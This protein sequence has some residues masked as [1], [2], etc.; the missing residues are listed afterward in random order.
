MKKNGATIV[1]IARVAG[2]SVSTVSRVTHNFPKIAESTRRRV[3]Q[4]IEELSYKPESRNFSRSARY[5]KNSIK[6][7]KIAFF[8]PDRFKIA[9]RTSLTEALINGVAAALPDNNVEMLFCML[10]PDGG[11][12]RVI[13]DGNVDGIICKNYPRNAEIAAAL[14][15]IPH[16]WCLSMPV[17]SEPEDQVCAD[18]R[19]LAEQTLDYFLE[20]GITTINYF[21]SSTE[22][23]SQM[24]RM[25]N[26]ELLS[27]ERGV[28]IRPAAIGDVK[29][30]EASPN[31]KIGIFCESADYLLTS[32]YVNLLHEG[33][34]VKNVCKL[35]SV[36]ISGDQIDAIDPALDRIDLRPEQIGRAAV[37]LLLWRL[38]H[39][40]EPGRRIL[41]APQIVRGNK[42][43]TSGK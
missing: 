39:P 29:S 35:L 34:D 26:I 3:M 5:G 18:C 14:K 32:L 24:E 17:S 43:N 13:S 22:E 42:Q 31:G 12:P 25:S 10:E 19:M 37:E 1:D 36:N 6:Y 7:G 30:L 41:I 11:L 28:K 40:D 4:A 15:G 33:A 21:S 20:S 9:A 23:Y 16:V 27:K 8:V 38:E 2:V